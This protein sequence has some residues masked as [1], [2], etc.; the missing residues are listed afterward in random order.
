MTRARLGVNR[1]NRL[2][3]IGFGRRLGLIR[4][5]ETAYTSAPQ[6]VVL[7]WRIRMRLRR[8]AASAIEQGGS[9]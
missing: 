3:S 9:V 4:S 5:G 8:A 2:G 1:P 6:R 7:V